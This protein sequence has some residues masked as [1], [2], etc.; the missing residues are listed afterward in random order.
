MNAQKVYEIAYDLVPGIVYNC[1]PSSDDAENGKFIN[2]VRAN[3]DSFVKAV[4][5]DIAT[6]AQLMVMAKVDMAK[7][8]VKPSVYSGMNGIYKNTDDN[9]PD[10]HG[11]WI[12]E[13]GRQCVCD[14]YRAARLFTPVE[15]IP[16]C[17]GFEGL[18]K[19][20]TPCYD[21]TEK[22][23]LPTLAEL[24][25]YIKQF[26]AEHKAKEYKNTGIRYDLGD[27]LPAVNA[28]Y[29]VDMLNIFGS[30]SAYWSGKV[31]ASIYFKSEQ[32]D[33]ILLPVR[34]DRR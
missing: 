29:L 32:G 11:A 28:Q 9:R 8:K 30:D 13:Q 16:E 24:K 25:A 27:V 3:P 22:L 20:I 31:N 18:E 1:F 19:C 33:G 6:V 15:N 26:K 7:A 21:Y 5:P 2:K 23:P 4:Y 10:V 14:G 34:K 17:K 12:D